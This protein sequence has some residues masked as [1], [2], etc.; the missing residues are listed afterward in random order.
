MA[1]DSSTRG[2]IVIKAASQLAKLT[3]S[4]LILYRAITAEPVQLEQLIDDNSVE[5]HLVRRGHAELDELAKSCEAPIEAITTELA[6]PAD[7]ILHTARTRDVDLIIL[8][9]HGHGLLER[10]IG[11]TAQKVFERADRNVLV[12]RTVL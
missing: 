6:T 2:P 11:T 1:L 12:V 9:S 8:G 7:G 3:S 5:D 10:L 4:E